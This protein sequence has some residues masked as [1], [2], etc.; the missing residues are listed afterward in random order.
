MRRGAN[1][2]AVGRDG[3]MRGPYM[4]DTYG[5]RA[6]KVEPRGKEAEENRC[7]T[8]EGLHSARDGRAR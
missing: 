7:G 2:E 5:K 6:K 1:G 4:G 8:R 3:A